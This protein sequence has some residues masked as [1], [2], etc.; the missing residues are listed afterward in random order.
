MARLDRDG[1]AVGALRRRLMLE[2][3]VAVADGLGGATEGFETVAA[4][5]ASVEWLR[6]DE[7]WRRGRPEQAATHRITLR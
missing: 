6:G 1:G 7:F 5:W 4:V 3:P 2:R